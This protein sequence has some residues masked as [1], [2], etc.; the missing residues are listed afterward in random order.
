MVDRPLMRIQVKKKPEAPS[1]RGAEDFNS[2]A[3][4]MVINSIIGLMIEIISAGEIK[5]SLPTLKDF[6]NLRRI[7]T[8]AALD[9]GSN[10][11]YTDRYG[12]YVNVRS[13]KASARDSFPLM[14]MTN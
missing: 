10:R 11:K 4:L 3:F 13:A 9:C 14:L 7:N 8:D 5:K 6:G 2:T 12:K 1:K